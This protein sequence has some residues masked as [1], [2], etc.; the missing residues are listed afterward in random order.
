MYQ[1][2]TNIIS[3]NLGSILNGQGH[4]SVGGKWEKRM[5]LSLPLTEFKGW[6]IGGKIKI[7]IEKKKILCFQQILNY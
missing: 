4:H 2:V 1:Y 3:E 7:F 6:K 5:V